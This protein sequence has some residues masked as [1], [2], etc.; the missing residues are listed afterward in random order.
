MQPDYKAAARN[1][2]RQDPE[3]RALLLAAI[4]QEPEGSD[5]QFGYLQEWVIVQPD[6]IAFISPVRAVAAV[7]VRGF[8]I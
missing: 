4:E 3:V 8:H 6:C 7:T 5:D 2:E 1:V